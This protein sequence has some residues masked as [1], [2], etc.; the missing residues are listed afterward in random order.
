MKVSCKAFIDS[1]K[2]PK[3]DIVWINVFFS[4]G[5]NRRAALEPICTHSWKWFDVGSG[6]WCT[7]AQPNN[8]TIDDAFWAGDSNVR[9]QHSRKKYVITFGTMMQVRHI[10]QNLFIYFLFT[11]ES[12]RFFFKNINF[13]LTIFF[14]LFQQ[15][16]FI[17]WF[18]CWS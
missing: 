9:I 3:S 15:G 11:F 8:K 4:L 17:K 12:F 7:Y 18:Y 6:K 13:R 10:P 5:M 2:Y 1:P 14:D 16:F